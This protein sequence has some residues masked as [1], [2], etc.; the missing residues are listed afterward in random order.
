MS[1]E[2]APVTIE[3]KEAFTKAAKK[4]GV[5]KSEVIRQAIRN[6]IKENR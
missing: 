5:Y 3:M 4:A 2:K 6:F 1:Q